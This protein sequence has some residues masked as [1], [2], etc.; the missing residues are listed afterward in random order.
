M[1]DEE[2][3]DYL[4]RH[5]FYGAC[6]RLNRACRELWHALVRDLRRLVRR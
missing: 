3:R 1:T 5:T 4:E 2:I 6:V